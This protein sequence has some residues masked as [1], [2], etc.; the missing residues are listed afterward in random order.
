MPR[1]D[2]E[3]ESSTAPLPLR[4]ANSL[5]NMTATFVRSALAIGLLALSTFVSANIDLT[6]APRFDVFAKRQENVCVEDDYLLGLQSFPQAATSLCS[7]YLGIGLVTQTGF[8]G[9][10]TLVYLHEMLSRLTCCF[11]HCNNN[12]PIDHANLYHRHSGCDHYH[13][14]IYYYSSIPWK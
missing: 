3:L 1:K 5:S 9:T 12:Y 2:I 8:A 14:H 6:T 11:K 10:S 7:C 4:A 13:K